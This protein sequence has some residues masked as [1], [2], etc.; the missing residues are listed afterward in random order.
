M[1]D[2]GNHHVAAP[3]GGFPHESL[4]IFCR[5]LRVETQHR[6]LLRHAMRMTFFMLGFIGIWFNKSTGKIG[7]FSRVP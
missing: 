3:G 5:W 6:R 4:S 1:N 7:S 2:S